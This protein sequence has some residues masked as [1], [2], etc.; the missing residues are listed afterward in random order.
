VGLS[1]LLALALLGL[2]VKDVA[3][4][5]PSPPVFA[6]DTEVVNL[7]VAVR[8]QG[9][10]LV[11]DLGPDD[12]LILE[13]GRPQVV[14]VFGRAHEAG[15]DEVLGLDLGLL[16]DTSTSM[17][18]E[19]KLS[20]EAAVRFLETI[21]RAR[22]LLTIFFDDE[23]RLSRYD[24]ENQQGLFGRIHAAKGGGNTALYDAITVYLS[25]I[26]GSAGRKVLVL[27]TDGEDTVSD[28]KRS[29]LVQIVRS[30][31]VT[32][33]PIA[34]SKGLRPG[35][36]TLLA[37]AFLQQLAD[38]TGGEVFTPSTSRDLPRI[39]QKILD[40]LSA[41]YVLGFTSD[42]QARDG[43]YRKLKVRVRREGLKVRHRA[44]YYAR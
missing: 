32:I 8:D 14:Q 25:R 1:H 31:A 23:I 42:R 27:F 10:N 5:A 35:S 6:V 22:E 38:L 40:A 30:S 18:E 15:Q 24:S 12:F 41:Q 34:F 28:V 36:P 3:Q 21:P 2:D 19:L 4:Q 20:Q 11:T 29:E 7:T 43:K 26:E 39:Y 37:R 17:L 9:G 13:D 44:G 16:M 33:Y